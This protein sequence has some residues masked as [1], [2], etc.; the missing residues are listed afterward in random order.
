MT[1]IQNSPKEV[2][3]IIP[4]SLSTLQSCM[5]N[6]GFLNSISTYGLLP[7]VA[8]KPCD[9]HWFLTRRVATTDLDDLVTWCDLS[10]I[11]YLDQLPPKNTN[12]GI[13]TNNIS[14]MFAG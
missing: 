3:T 11:F 7:F 4:C 13:G 10:T 6:L 14:S 9:S 2:L 1:I 8:V 12:I 5:L